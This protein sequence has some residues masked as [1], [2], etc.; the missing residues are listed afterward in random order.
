[1]LHNKLPQIIKPIKLCHQSAS[2]G[3]RMRGIVEIPKSRKLNDKVIGETITAHLHLDFGQDEAGHNRVVVVGEFTAELLCQRCL[4]GYETKLA[5]KSV[6]SPV[7]NDYDAKNLPGNY[8]P[9]W[10]PEDEIDMCEWAQ[11]ELLLSLPIVPKHNFDCN[12]HIQQH[13]HVVSEK[14]S[15]FA[16]LKVHLE[17]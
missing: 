2:N 10:A 3:T 5:I 1:M 13:R 9:L 12:K 8:E 14:A 17:R 4:Q 11:E 6:L 15:P 7:A 16:Q